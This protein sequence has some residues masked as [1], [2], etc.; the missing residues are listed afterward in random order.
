MPSHR[1]TICLRCRGRIQEAGAQ[2]LCVPCVNELM[3]SDHREA[4]KAFAPGDA[5][6]IVQGVFA[7]QTATVVSIEEDGVVRARS[8]I[9][10]IPLE[11][12]YLPWQLAHARNVI[13][14]APAA[15]PSP[16]R[17]STYRF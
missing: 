4:A 14:E 13:P 3:K 8:K 2:R 1:E 11:I 9:M 5:V 17:H 16:A 12:E 15:Q 10:N 7:G 6:Q